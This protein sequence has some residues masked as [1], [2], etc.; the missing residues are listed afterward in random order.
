MLVLD[1]SLK[2][3]H[4]LDIPHRQKP[5]EERLEF[6]HVHGHDNAIHP[7]HDAVFL[8]AHLVV[9]LFN[10]VGPRIHTAVQLDLACRMPHPMDYINEKF[11]AKSSCWLTME[12]VLL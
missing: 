6:K 7:S 10:T 2:L 9:S 4:L 3:L 1:H 8:L 5:L 11:E 12:E